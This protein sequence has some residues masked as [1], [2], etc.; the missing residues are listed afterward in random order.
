[1]SFTSDEDNHDEKA[2]LGLVMEQEKRRSATKEAKPEK[3]EKQKKN[4]KID[5]NFNENSLEGFNTKSK[6]SIMS[7]NE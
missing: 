7:N 4:E 1:M 2:L 5:V 3:K 6:N